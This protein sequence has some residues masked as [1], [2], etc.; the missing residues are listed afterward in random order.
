MTTESPILAVLRDRKVKSRP[1]AIRANKVKRELD[2]LQITHVGFVS[3]SGEH[4]IWM[5]GE[6]SPY[7]RVVTT[8]AN[9]DEPQ[10]RTEGWLLDE[11][12]AGR[13]AWISHDIS[14][15]SNYEDT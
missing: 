5:F 11:L 1:S 14:D 15:M 9:G 13:L 7:G 2:R 8:A 12:K 6:D 10:E 3:E 4:T